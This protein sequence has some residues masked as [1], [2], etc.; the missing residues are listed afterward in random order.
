MV[1]PLTKLEPGQI[2]TNQEICNIFKCS[3]QGGMR[4]SNKTNTLVIVSDRTKSIYDDRWIE[5]IF[6]YTGMGL[7]GDQKLDYAQN[8]TLNNSNKNGVAVFLF[9]VFRSTQYIYQG[10]VKL[11]KKPFEELQLD[12]NNKKRKVW[13]FPL[14]LMTSDG[15]LDLDAGLLNNLDQVKERK[16][17]KLSNKE[18]LELAK[19]TGRKN[20][21]SR[22]VSSTQP[23]RNPYV[24]EYTNRRADGISQ[25]CGDPAP[26]IKKNGEPFL[27]VHHINWLTKGGEDTIE[28]TVALCPNCHRKMHSLD[29]LQDRKK[30]FLRARP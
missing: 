19:N 3:P 17:K 22:R 12:V 27:E 20:P 26:F 15:P 21:G 29:L 30:L 16:A 24:V 10:Q 28:N 4:K 11:T 6:Y 13:I 5:D 7:T 23:D 2:L 9:E 1:A 18:L 25:L 8:K 14:Q